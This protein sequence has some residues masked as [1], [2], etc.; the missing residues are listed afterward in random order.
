L[1]PYDAEG[2]RVGVAT[3]EYDYDHGFHSP[4]HIIPS[5]TF[6]PAGDEQ[7]DADE[8]WRSSPVRHKKKQHI[9]VSRKCIVCPS[10]T[11]S[12]GFRTKKLFS[13]FYV[14]IGI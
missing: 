9:L 11:R 14:C 12:L 3:G 2:G 8:S 10:L 13:I 4:D 5:A 6:P 7:S 1:A